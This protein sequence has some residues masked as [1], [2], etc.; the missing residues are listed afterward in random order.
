MRR[1]Q[2]GKSSKKRTSPTRTTGGSGGPR[3]S[4]LHL[5]STLHHAGAR[6]P[7]HERRIPHSPPSQGSAHRA[8]RTVCR[9]VGPNRRRAARARAALP[10]AA[11]SRGGTSS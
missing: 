7:P 8:D 1:A 5:P 2:S 6:F 9:S 10:T 11:R 3:R 4:G